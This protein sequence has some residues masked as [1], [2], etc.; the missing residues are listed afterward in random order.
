VAANWQRKATSRHCSKIITDGYTPGVI[1]YARLCGVGTN[2]PGVWAV[3]A[4]VMA[5]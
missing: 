3:S 1:Y 5:V 2:G 4:G